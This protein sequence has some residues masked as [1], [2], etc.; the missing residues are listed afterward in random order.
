MSDEPPIIAWFSAGATS[1]VACKLALRAGTPVRIVYIA[2]DSAHPD[3]DRFIR[4]CE[5]W[6]GQ[7]IER[8][9]NEKYKDQF[10]VIEKRRYV[11]GPG[12]ALCTFELK[13]SVRFAVEKQLGEWS[14]Q[15]FGM[16]FSK[17]EINRAI[18]FREQ[19]PDAKAS[20]PLIEAR[21]TK[22][23]CLGMLEAAGIEVP[24]MYRLGFNN[25]NCIGCV[26]GGQYYWNLI[27]K[28]FPESYERMAV[29]ERN[30]G[31]SCIKGMTL[32]ELPVGAGRPNELLEATECG[33]F[34]QVEF[35]D[36]IDKRV[37]SIEDGS[38]SIGDVA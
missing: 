35:A 34:C 7:P 32:D 11:N 8:W 19:Y 13:K 26:K 15:V 20:F 18:R 2:I 33:V 37:E 29:A 3:N 27:R 5:A 1:A 24:A 36:I 14:S 16:E 25:N 22:R 23:D 30:L 38:V 9:R 28:H 10:D 31:R 6:Y 17:R 12:G 4:E 21:L